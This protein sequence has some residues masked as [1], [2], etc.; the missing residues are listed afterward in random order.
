MFNNNQRLILILSG[1][2]LSQ[3]VQVGVF[4]LFLAQKLH[5]AG[6][7]LSIIGWLLAVQWIVVLVIAPL[8]PA[9]SR[10]MGLANLNKV[11]GFLTLAGLLCLVTPNLP[12]AILASGFVGAGLILRWVACDTLVVKLSRPANVGRLIGVHETLMGF[13][14]AVGPLLFTVYLLDEIFYAA[15]FITILSILAFLLNFQHFKH[16]EDRK[17]IALLKSDYPIIKIAFLIALVGG[18]I[19]T[20]SVALFPFY[21]A[22]DGF[23]I[24]QSAW[25]ISA[26][27]LGGTLLQLPLGFLVDKVGYRHAQLLACLLGLAGVLGL[28]YSPSSFVV[29]YGILFM[30]GG[31]VGA[32]NTLAVIQA[33][34]Q[35]NENRS[36][37]AMAFI[38]MCYTTGS[39]F[40]PIVTAN[41]LN[42]LP[43]DILLLI[44]F[45]I[46]TV[47]S[48]I[49]GKELLKA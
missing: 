36:A 29:I 39:I 11:S 3:I 24:K 17:N 41:I 48:I 35:I 38:A 47:I 16:T 2:F 43:N 23:S 18:F 25:F 46:I 33:G 34:S 4:P 21:F 5:V 8:V 20:A 12:F 28:Y 30:F 1:S 7:S 26:F 22:I 31:A 37:S 15:I 9:L 10:M 32:F 6:V 44:Y 14:I 49:I 27:G 40:G 19:E 13:G 45:L 42:H